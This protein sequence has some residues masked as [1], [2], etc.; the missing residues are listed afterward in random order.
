M[1]KE[2]YYFSQQDQTCLTMWGNSNVG[3]KAQI[4]M[5]FL[6]HGWAC[7]GG[8]AW[9]HLQESCQSWGGNNNPLCT[10]VCPERSQK[11]LECN[12]CKGPEGQKLSEPP[13]MCGSEKIDKTGKTKSP[14]L[15]PVV[16]LNTARFPARINL[17][18]KG[19]TS[20]MW[21]W[22]AVLVALLLRW[23]WMGGSVGLYTDPLFLPCT[24]GSQVLPILHLE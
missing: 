7:T 20:R 24:P 2:Y 15:C 11:S 21:M 5:A 8:L 22:G 10:P 1:N 12:P 17:C 6:K 18:Y 13:F 9:V 3:G 14:L 23:V 4:Q 19:R 16:S